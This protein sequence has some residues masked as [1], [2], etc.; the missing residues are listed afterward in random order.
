YKKTRGLASFGSNET[1]YQTFQK[2]NAWEASRQCFWNRFLTTGTLKNHY[3]AWLS[4]FLEI[5]NARF[6][7]LYLPTFRLCSSSICRVVCN[8]AGLYCEFCGA[9]LEHPRKPS[10]DVGS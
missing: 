6:H 7:I 1:T 5:G 3:C 10:Y 9:R 2:G 4:R 8:G